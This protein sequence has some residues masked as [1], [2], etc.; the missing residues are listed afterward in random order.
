MYRKATLVRTRKHVGMRH[1]NSRL[2][3]ERLV[4][5]DSVEIDVVNE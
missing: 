2:G 1:D 5:V 3:V 4:L